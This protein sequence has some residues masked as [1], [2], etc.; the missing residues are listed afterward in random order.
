MSNYLKVV[1][2]RRF[3]APSIVAGLVVLVYANSVDNSFHYDDLHV[4]VENPHIE[5][6]SLIPSFF[7]DPALFSRDADK[8]MYRP[9]LLTSFA[10]NYEWGGRQVY[11]YHVVNILM[12]AATSLLVW[13]LLGSMNANGL[14]RFFGALLFALHPIGTEPVNYISSRSELMVGLFVVASFWLYE[15]SWASGRTAYIGSVG[16]FVF[17][18]LAKSVGIA[19]PA[20][21]LVRD[22]TAGRSIA[23]TWQ[24]YLPYGFCSVLYLVLVS[25]SL[26]KAVLDAPV[27]SWDVQLGTQIKAWVYYAKLLCFPIGLNVHHQFFESGIGPV[28][29][30]FLLLLL[31]FAVAVSSPGD[32]RGIRLFGLLWF[33]I[34]LAPASVVPLYV[35]VNDHRLYLPLIGLIII[36]SSIPPGQLRRLQMPLIVLVVLLGLLVVRRNDVWE[37]E[38]TLWSDAARKSPHPL[39]PVA[40]V[41]LGN[42]AKDAGRMSEAVGYFEQALE[43]DPEHTAA[44]NNLATVFDAMGD[45]EQAIA[46]YERLLRQKKDAMEVRYNL[47]RALQRSGHSERARGVYLTIPDTSVHFELVANNLG[48][49]HEKESRTDSALFYYG[50]ALAVNPETKDAAE[51]FNRLAQQLLQTGS[52]ADV[53]SVCA[54]LLA[55]YAPT[56]EAQFYRSVALFQQRRYSESIDQNQRLVADFST[57][58]I[59]FLQLGNV[60]ESAGRK[61]EAVL[62]YRRLLSLSQDPDMRRRTKARLQQLSEPGD[63]E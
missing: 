57:F 28:I 31:S 5:D 43:V 30:L 15:R 18:L 10:L 58:E 11:S 23:R 2:N 21:I 3:L 1:Q 53:E 13:C 51:N 17:G 19:L 22:L 44:Q 48:T 59:G 60:L 32:R 8:G 54:S 12:H 47:A 6:V 4:L 55:G 61:K 37:N 20:L 56:A 9:L 36:G 25:S 45:Q 33:A 49:L 29:L 16:C 62:A 35:L 41:H 24:R 26:R 52:D 27:R 38:H 14:F 50:R 40:Y 63:N 46:I 7:T 42:Y 34:T 39:I